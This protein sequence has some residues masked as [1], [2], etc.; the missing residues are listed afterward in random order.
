MHIEVKRLEI[1]DLYKLTA[2]MDKETAIAANIEWPFT[3]EI[4][5]N[6][7]NNYN[8]WGIWTGG[9]CPG[10]LIGAIEIKEDQ[11]TAYVV[12]KNWRNAGVATFAMQLIKEKFSDKQLW[13][14]INPQNRASLRVAE[15][16]NMR[17]VY[18]NNQ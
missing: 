11:E 3:R 8:T 5:T 2:V 4:A 15:K 16:A 7:I 1:R 13:C 10:S 9:D 6:F 18:H 14:F 17:I 12:H